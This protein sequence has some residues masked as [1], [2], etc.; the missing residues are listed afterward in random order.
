MSDLPKRVAVTVLFSGSHV[1]YD[2]WCDFPVKVGDN[3]IVATKRGEATVVVT[4]VK[5]TSERAQASVK[6]IVA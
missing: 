5:P 4:A 2:Y 3:V 1:G 6:G